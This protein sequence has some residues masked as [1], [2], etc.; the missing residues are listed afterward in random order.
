M[1]RKALEAAAK[2]MRALGH[3]VRLGVMECLARGEHNVSELTEQL[4]CSQSMMS[5]QLAILEHQHLIATRKEGTHKYCSIQNTDFLK[6]FGCLEGHL[7]TYLHIDF[8]ATADESQD[9][10]GEVGRPLA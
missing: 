1:D 4:D 9:R 3:P 7:Q 6:L 5:Q 2:V 8:T 10:H